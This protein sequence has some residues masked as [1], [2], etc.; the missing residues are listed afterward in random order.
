M[1][2]I[3]CNS[4]HAV[5]NRMYDELEK[6]IEDG[7]VFSLTEKL[8]GTQFVKRLIDE[9]NNGKYKYKHV[10]FLNQRELINIDKEEDYGYY[11]VMK[12]NIY[13]HL[14][15][16]YKNI[17]SP[18]YRDDSSI[19]NYKKILEDNPLDVT[20]LF[21][22]SSGAILN[23]SEVT[24]EN[25][26]VH[27]SKLTAREK[28]NNRQ[29]YDIELEEDS[30]ITLGYDNVLKSRNI[31]LIALGKDKR[32]FVEKIFESTDENNSAIELLKQ[33]PNLTIFV[34]KEAGYKSEEEVN[35]LIKE[36]QR[37]KEIE[38]LRRFEKEATIQ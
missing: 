32:K 37:K 17:F 3:V 38:E 19:E 24:D 31:F 35:K 1:K 11:R 5:F 28:N 20:I 34:D 15:V 26:D 36:K 22:D 4:E 23:Y 18:E 21:I 12:K 14:D 2:Y 25:R 7:A 9:Y 27:I 29:R 13:K 8:I 6:Y 30:V 10:I 33:H 16:D